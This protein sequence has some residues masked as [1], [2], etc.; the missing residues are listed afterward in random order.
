MVAK[1][2]ILEQSLPQYLA[3]WVDKSSDLCIFD[4]SHFETWPLRILQSCPW[5]LECALTFCTAEE[6]EERNSIGEDLSLPNLTHLET[7][8]NVVPEVRGNRKRGLK[9]IDISS[10]KNVAL[11]S[12][13]IKTPMVSGASASEDH[14]DLSQFDDCVQMTGISTLK[15]SSQTSAQIMLENTSVLKVVT[16]ESSG[17]LLKTN[18][19]VKQVSIMP[20]FIFFHVV[21]FLN[22]FYSINDINNMLLFATV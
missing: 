15:V 11:R 22:F 12:S 14:V 20:T 13:G 4:A 9:V 7:V 3:A 10:Q 21:N 5:F 6:E 19:F 8:H 2:A 18:E 16:G 17:V 1:G